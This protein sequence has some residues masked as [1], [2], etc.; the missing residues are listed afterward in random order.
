[1]FKEKTKLVELLKTCIHPSQHKLNNPG[2]KEGRREGR[3]GDKGGRNG[4]RKKGRIF[5][6][7]CVFNTF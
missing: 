4:G 2:R 3:K 7:N 1:M 6:F 5:L